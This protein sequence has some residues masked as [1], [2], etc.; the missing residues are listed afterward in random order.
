MKIMPLKQ[1]DK[2]KKKPIR[3]LANNYTSTSNIAEKS[4]ILFVFPLMSLMK[5]D[6]KT[7]PKYIRVL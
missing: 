2:Q 3:I 7:N 6:S 4:N 5:N 1:K